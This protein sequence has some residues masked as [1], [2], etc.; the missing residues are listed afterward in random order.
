MASAQ[1]RRAGA[2]QSSDAELDTELDTE[3]DAARLLRIRSAVNRA[4]TRYLHSAG[5]LRDK[6]KKKKKNQSQR[7]GS[8]PAHVK[9]L[10]A[11]CH[12]LSLP[13]RYR[14][15]HHSSETW[16]YYRVLLYI[17]YIAPPLQPS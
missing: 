6:K 1:L 16:L 4:C 9:Y 11:L 12:A 7:C 15:H 3:L 2:A 8:D 10:S 13:C 5:G 14:Y 17:E